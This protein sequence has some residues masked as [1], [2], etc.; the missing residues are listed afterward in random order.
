ML[1]V[2]EMS[3]EEINE[4]LE[5]GNY[6]HLAC[7]SAD[8]PYVVPIHYALDGSDIYIY[9]TEGKKS[10]II[11][12]NPKICLQV[13][14]VIAK[15]DWRSVIV[16][17]IAKPIVSGKNREKAIKLIRTINPTLT[18][19]LSIRWMDD[20]IRENHEVVYRIE[21]RTMTGRSTNK[22]KIS[23]AFANPGAGQGHKVL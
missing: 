18:P 2:D 22:V 19:A 11:D 17:G 1:E 3:S 12:A 21:P 10:E 5:R 16:T 14:E 7:S 13:E 23:A 8:Q 15:D 6:G 20:W 9:T 4:V